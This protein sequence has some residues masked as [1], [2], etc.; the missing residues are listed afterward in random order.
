M[1][2]KLSN[3]T[4]FLALVFGLFFTANIVPT[5]TSATTL[6]QSN[7]FGI[8]GTI[9]S[10]PPTTSATITTP[11][12]GQSFSNLPVNI[13]G[14]CISGLLIKIFINGVFSGSTDCI[15]DSYSISSDLFIGTNNIVAEDY[16]SLNQSGPT[17][18]TVTV[19][20]VNNAQTAESLVNLTSNYAKIGAD[21]G[22]L[23]TW[24]I[25]ISGGTPPYAISVNWG[26]GKQPTLLSQTTAGGL[27]L[28]H[29]YSIAGAYNITINATD[30]KGGISFLQLVG[31]GNGPSSQ[32]SNT[33]Q[34]NTS[35]KTVG[36]SNGQL[37]LIIG[38]LII[39]PLIAFWLGDMHQRKIIQSK[40]QNRQKLF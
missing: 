38:L 30:A 3:P 8:S 22:S 25:E 27:N 26:D 13:S 33:S 6:S 18:S 1:L 4:S 16:D 21:P 11:S 28:T 5:I 24:P 17:S 7:G 15:N 36:L 32:T 35:I 20:Y 31:V 39:I 19:S 10:P 37:G 2:K 40:F 34:K 29:T 23:L 14:V 12:N 9:T